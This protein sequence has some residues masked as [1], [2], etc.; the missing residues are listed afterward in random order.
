MKNTGKLIVALSE[1][2]TVQ[3]C[4]AGLVFTLLMTGEG[5]TNFTT[6][7]KI[8]MLVSAFTG[9]DYPTVEAMRNGETYYCMILKPKD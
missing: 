9:D 8:Q 4:K 6:A 7:G 3:L 1:F 2:G 5:L